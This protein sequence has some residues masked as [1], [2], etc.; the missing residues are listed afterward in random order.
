MSDEGALLVLSPPQLQSHLHHR[1]RQ[2]H[3]V[4]DAHHA[5]MPKRSP[6]HQSLSR[7]SST[8]LQRSARESL[9]PEQRRP[10]LYLHERRRSRRQAEMAIHH[11]R[12]HRANSRSAR[13]MLFCKTIVLTTFCL[14]RRLFRRQLASILASR[15][16]QSVLRRRRG[17]HP[18][19]GLLIMF[20]KLLPQCVRRP[21]TSI[22]P[23]TSNRS[24]RRNHP[25]PHQELHGGFPTELQRIALR[26]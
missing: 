26:R 25:P 9:D 18:L 6:T 10:T 24:H 16:H 11:R 7:K 17:I 3:R 5:T 22:I 14:R 8:F 12:A 21:Q 1:P 15:C 2:L 23:L 20:P 19:S 4:L 13:R